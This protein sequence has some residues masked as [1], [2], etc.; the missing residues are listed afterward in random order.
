[1]VEGEHLE[2]LPGF[3]IEEMD[4]VAEG[5]LVIGVEVEEGAVIGEGALLAVGIDLPQ[6]GVGTR[7]ML[8]R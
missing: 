8:L 4:S 6:D 2:D 7:Q 5:E 3:S 1:M